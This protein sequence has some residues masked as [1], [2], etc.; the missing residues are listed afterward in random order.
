MSAEQTPDE[1]ARVADSLRRVIDR[2]VGTT[3]PAAEFD[4]IA[5][6]LDE[7]ADRLERYEQHTLFRLGGPVVVDGGVT[8]FSPVTGRL[9]PFAPPVR[10]TSIGPHVEGVVTFGHAYE[11]PP[12]HVHGGFVA[13]TLDELLGMTMA[14]QHLPGMTGRLT[15]RYRRPTPLHTELRVVGEVTRV[16]GRKVRVEGAIERDGEPCAVAE[17]LFLLVDFGRFRRGTAGG[18]A[19]EPGP[20]AT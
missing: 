12:G 1:I 4:G 5:D 18:P 8:E 3:A 19:S 10:V 2:M 20:P 6:R 16:D 7:L 11:G 13:A 9:H 14:V 15:V 17:G